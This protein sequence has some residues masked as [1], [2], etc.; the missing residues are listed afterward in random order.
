MQW[1]LLHDRNIS[2]CTTVPWKGEQ[3]AAEL[4]SSWTNS[5]HFLP[6]EDFVSSYYVAFSND[7]RDWTTLHDGYAEW[8]RGNLSKRMTQAVTTPL[9]GNVQ[10]S[11]AVILR[12]RG[13]RHAGNESVF[14]TCGGALH[15][16]PAPEL[17]RQLVSPSW[18]HGL[19][20]PQ[21]VTLKNN[22]TAPMYQKTKNLLIKININKQ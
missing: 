2:D 14:H 4:T 9:L 18:D 3:A 17:E 21:S 6:S 12:E 11:P 19:S 16:H 13:Q 5:S 1:S 15:P 10:T 20:A 22:I 7:S 8:V